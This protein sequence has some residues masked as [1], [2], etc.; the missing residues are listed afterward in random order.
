MAQARNIIIS[1]DAYR[2]KYKGL[3]SEKTI[4]SVA[5]K[6]WKDLD[7]KFKLCDGHMSSLGHLCF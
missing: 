2:S 4:V 5:Y 3:H 1:T 7:K 6:I